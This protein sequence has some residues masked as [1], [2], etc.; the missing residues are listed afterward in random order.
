MANPSPRP[1]Q[2]TEASDRLERAREMLDT[3]AA[4][5]SAANDLHGVG[6]QGLAALLDLIV[7]QME[8]RTA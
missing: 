6:S 2:D 4:L 3:L 7:R 8:G 1:M 5:I